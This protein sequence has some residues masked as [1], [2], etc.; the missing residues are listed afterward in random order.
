MTWL[1]FNCLWHDILDFILNHHDISL[2]ASTSPTRIVIF[3]R[4]EVNM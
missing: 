3:R 2:L 4:H 1:S